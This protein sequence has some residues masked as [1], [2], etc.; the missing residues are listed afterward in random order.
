MRKTEDNWS[1]VE[2]SIIKDYIMKNNSMNSVD[3]ANKVI[4]E[5]PN[6]IK[7]IRYEGSSLVQH[8]RYLRRKIS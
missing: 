8:V 7:T 5:R 1:I 3:I 4:Q 2:D 6:G